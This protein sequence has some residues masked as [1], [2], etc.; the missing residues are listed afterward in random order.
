MQK[1]TA[2]RKYLSFKRKTSRISKEKTIPTS[3]DSPSLKFYSSINDLPL[4]LFW[5]ICLDENETKLQKLVISGSPTDL[6]L[7]DAW[8]AITLEYADLM[9]PESKRK[10]KEDGKL[11]QLKYK[12]V[13]VHSALHLLTSAM[14]Y[15]TT[16]EEEE[17]FQGICDTLTR[18][19]PSIK[20]D[21]KKREA[22][23][24]SFERIKALANKWT[25]DINQKQSANSKQVENEVKVQY[26]HFQSMLNNV[27]LFHKMPHVSA[28]Q[29][30]VLEFA[31]Y[32]KAM[33]DAI[34]IQ[35]NQNARVRNN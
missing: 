31:L 23:L 1:L 35:K 14:P 8:S 9:S 34:E 11:E 6:H 7:Q 18:L 10:V 15:S 29:L 19:F 22:L 33:N 28:S 5:D 12:S 3:E 17:V 13:F 27:I 32:Y 2:L 21:Y 16:P 26:A 20:L 24:P 25:I 4:K 30:T